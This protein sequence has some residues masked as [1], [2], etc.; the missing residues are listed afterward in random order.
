MYP[1]FLNSCQLPLSLFHPRWLFDAPAVLH[2]RWH[3]SWKISEDALRAPSPARDP[4]SSR[5]RF[6][7]RGEEMVKGADNSQTAKEVAASKGK[8]KGK[9]TTMQKPGKKAL[10]AAV[11]MSQLL[12]SYVP[13]PSSAILLED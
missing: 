1:A 8:G 12:D 4:D 10:A 3:M 13:P 9:G 6:H 5:S 7:D 2:D 11:E